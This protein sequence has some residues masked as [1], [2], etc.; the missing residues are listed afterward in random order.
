[1]PFLSIVYM[2]L[3]VFFIKI[4][5]YVTCTTT[6]IKLSAPTNSTF[7]A[8]SFAARLKTGLELF[9]V[10]VIT[11]EFIFNISQEEWCNY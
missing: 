8:L 7:S 4:T 11:V 5:L 1:M 6:K 3:M 9:V 2:I 10:V